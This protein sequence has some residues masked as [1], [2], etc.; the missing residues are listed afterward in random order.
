MLPEYEVTRQRCVSS[1]VGALS[2]PLQGGLRLI[3][4]YS[5]PL[6]PDPLRPNRS[7]AI[8]RLNLP[9][10]RSVTSSRVRA[11]SKNLKSAA[12]SG[13][14]PA[15]SQSKPWPATVGYLTE[16]LSASSRGPR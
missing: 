7:P 1:I 6:V 5:R 2:P 14:E 10:E 15:P 12:S 9:V 3:D 16:C 4:S 8:P 11:A 13:Q